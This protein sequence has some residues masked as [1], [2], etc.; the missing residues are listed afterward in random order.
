MQLNRPA[1]LLG[2]HRSGT[3]WLGDALSQ[4]PELAYWPEPRQVW[5]YRNWFRDDDRLTEADATPPIA[6]YIRSRFDRFTRRHSATRFC[7]KTPSNCL[8]VPFVREVLPD[9]RFVLIIR[10]GR[11]V[12]RSTQEIHRQGVYYRRILD[13]LH[14]CDAKR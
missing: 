1:I 10:D 13:R 2:T 12:L 14:E 11:A 8:R 3:T 7:E 6:R 4:A 5:V 9:A